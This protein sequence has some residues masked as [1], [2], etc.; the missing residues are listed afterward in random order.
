MGTKGNE[1]PARSPFFAAGE[2]MPPRRC[3]I[4]S[5]HWGLRRASS[6]PVSAPQEETM[7]FLQ[8]KKGSSSL[9][10]RGIFWLGSILGLFR[11]MNDPNTFA[12]TKLQSSF[13]RFWRW[14]SFAR[15]HYSVIRI[16]HD[17]LPFPSPAPSSVLIAIPPFVLTAY[18][19]TH[20]T[21]LKTRAPMILLP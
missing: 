16:S 4:R 20:R 2:V 18:S 15:R 12:E 5:L 6:C 21:I 8:F 1:Y 17:A 14:R 19:T 10:R 9:G 3:G 13:T 11:T 7:S